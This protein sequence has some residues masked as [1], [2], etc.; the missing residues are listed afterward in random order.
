MEKKEHYFKNKEVVHMAIMAAAM[1]LVSCMTVPLVLG[2]S[3][4]GIRTIACGLFL[5]IIIAL[6]YVRV[7][8]VGAGTI[9]TL[10]ASV[11]MVFF[12]P[13]ILLFTV[14]AGICTDLYFLIIGKKITI[15][16][17]IGLG[18]VL[19]GSMMIIATFAGIVFL[20]DTT[21]AVLFSNLL[22]LGIG[23]LGSAFLGGFGSF[24]ATK[25]F[26]EFKQLN[27]NE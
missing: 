18:V 16:T 11:P 1:L 2:I 4:P 5:G 24:L 14:A 13:V 9:T 15:K 21:F 12:S 7:P 6:T 17:T 22:A 20:N 23:F 25:I 10:L 8:K 3:L 26:K 19:M 27:V